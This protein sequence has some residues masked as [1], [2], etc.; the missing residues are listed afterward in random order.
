MGE[1]HAINTDPEAMRQKRRIAKHMAELLVD[2]PVV[3]RPDA[4]DA[5]AERLKDLFLKHSD[6]TAEEAAAEVDH[7]LGLVL[8]RLKVLKPARRRGPR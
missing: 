4:L 8:K 6:M 3:A 5:E 2:L 1:A 7:V